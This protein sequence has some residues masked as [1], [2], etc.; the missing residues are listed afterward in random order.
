MKVETGFGEIFFV[1]GQGGYFPFG[2]NGDCAKSR[3]K[4]QV[5]RVLCGMRLKAAYLVGELRGQKESNGLP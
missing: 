1:C 5:T 2:L 4:F 3:V